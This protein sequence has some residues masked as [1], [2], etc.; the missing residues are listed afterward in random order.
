VFA[1]STFSR[2]PLQYWKWY[3]YID[4]MRFAWGGLTYG[5]YEDRDVQYIGG[6]GVLDFFNLSGY[7]SAW[8]LVGYLSIFLPVYI[9]LTYLALRFVNHSK[10]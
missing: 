1:S 7:G 5:Q 9:V 2:L 4:F 3:S 10:R 8:Q 6:S